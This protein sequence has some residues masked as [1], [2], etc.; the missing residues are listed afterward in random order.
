[1][2]NRNFSSSS[3]RYGFNGKEKDTENTWGDAQYD[4]GFRIFNPRYGK[5]L[6]VDPLT[7]SYPMLT[8]YQFASN[9]PIDGIDLDGLE[10]ISVHHYNNGEVAKTE[11]YKMT[12][13]DIKRLGGTPAGI[14]SSVAYGPG[15]KGILHYYYDKKGE[16][17]DALWEQQQ[18]DGESDLAYHGLYSGQG[19]VT[20]DGH[21]KSTNYNFNE[22]PI[23]WAD[24]IAKRHDKDYAEAASKNYAGFLDD[25]RT[26]QAD[27]DMVRRIDDFVGSNATTFPIGNLYGP[28]GVETPVRT[29]YSTE[30][31]Y[32]L[33][34]QR[35][36]INALAIYKQWKIEK[37][38]GN[39]N[40]YKYNRK[41]FMMEHPATVLILDQAANK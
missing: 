27:I 10:Y 33:L 19:A 20:Y 22:Q 6:S 24:A 12:D 39:D 38:L 9:R 28:E 40:L 36:M 7:K 15:G 11:F 8:P 5:F 18:T 32:T 14:H 30:L 2:P 17:I 37:N 21:A 26:L 13:K 25:I 29:S 23:D 31:D 16:R 35:T 34:G 41:A 4:Y 1:M 3:Y